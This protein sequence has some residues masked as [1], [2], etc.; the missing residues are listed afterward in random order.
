MN[1]IYK[2]INNLNNNFYI[3]VTTKSLNERL[4]R[5][6]RNAFDFNYKTHL[7][8][9]MRKYGK[10]NFN[11][12]LVDYCKDMKS[13]ISYIKKLKPHYNMTKGGDGGDTSKSPNYIKSMKEYH[14]K[15]SKKSYATYGMLGKKQTDNQK[16]IL[17]KFQK[18]HWQSLSKTER[19]KRGNSVKG[20]NNGM[21][22]KVPTNA[23]KITFRN[24]KYNSIIEAKRKTGL[25][26]YNIMKEVKN[27]RQNISLDR[28][29]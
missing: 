21:Y 28:T 22:G 3:G 29:I 1:K 5:H 12:K 25:T 17:S 11:I 27:G 26:I 8:K 24:K 7:Y 2:I 19:N 9:A 4:D 10:E 14:N 16:Q 18:K 23:I 20:K 15:K 6:F 13:E